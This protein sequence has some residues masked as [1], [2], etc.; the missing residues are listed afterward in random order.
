MADP[1]RVLEGAYACVA[2]YG[3]AKVT[4]D[5]VAREAGMSRATVY[6][7]F[8]G[9][10]DEVLGA[11]VV[12]EMDEFFGRMAVAV[13]DAPDFAELVERAL[14]FAQREITEHAVL[15]TVLATEPDRLLPYMTTGQGRILG[16]V[17]AYLRPLLDRE[18]AAGRVRP[19]V[20][21]DTAA[22]YVASMG[23]SLMATPG[24]FDLTDPSVIRDLV[25]HELLAGILTAEALSAPA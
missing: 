15:Q 3:F 23:L 12:M 10:R 14:A 22:T 2:R 11:M 18:A 24:R 13:A 5:D 17:I 20:D 7:L 6:R 9:G 1:R 21:L 16:A 4:V 8:P 19:D 25:R